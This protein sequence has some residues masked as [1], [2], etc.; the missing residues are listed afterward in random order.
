MFSELISSCIYSIVSPQV[1]LFV[2][3][4]IIANGS[5]ATLNCSVV[6]GNPMNYTFKWFRDGKDIS[7]NDISYSESYQQ[8]VSDKVGE[9]NCTVNN[10]AGNGSDSVNISL[11]G[12]CTCIHTLTHTPVASSMH[13]CC[14]S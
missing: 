8:I 10:T 5:N 2:H 14:L 12:K 7:P 13:F 3:P 1:Q 9:Y 6:K 4:G 11:G